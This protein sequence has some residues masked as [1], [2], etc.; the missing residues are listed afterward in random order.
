MPVLQLSSFD[1]AGTKKLKK[2]VYDLLACLHRVRSAGL[3]LLWNRGFLRCA[4]VNNSTTGGN[5][6]N[7]TLELEGMASHYHEIFHSSRMVDMY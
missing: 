7:A 3:A 4:A 1:P 6:Y 2:P 5:S